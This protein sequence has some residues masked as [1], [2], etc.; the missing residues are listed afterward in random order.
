M[1]SAN[2]TSNAYDGRIDDPQLF[3]SIAGKTMSGPDGDEFMSP[4]VYFILGQQYNDVVKLRLWQSP[5]AQP[6][7]KMMR[8]D[9]PFAGGSMTA[10]SGWEQV[11]T[12]A[13]GY[14]EVAVSG[15][16]LGTVSRH[17]HAC[18]RVNH[19]GVVSVGDCLLVG[20]AMLAAPC[21][22]MLLAAQNGVLVHISSTLA[23]RI[24][25]MPFDCFHACRSR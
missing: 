7:L 17:V 4:S 3:A 23:P 20:P 12:D 8:Y 13:T 22:A 16:S 6:S 11:A 5:G 25:I 9:R 19:G 18:M 21:A 14:A 2:N 15:A 10:V 1:C 24:S